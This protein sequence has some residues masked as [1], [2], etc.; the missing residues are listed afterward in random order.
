ME[1]SF[2]V[3]GLALH[4][5]SVLIAGLLVLSIKL[6]LHIKHVLYDEIPLRGSGY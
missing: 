5:H 6:F 3:L 2:A 4:L 1:I